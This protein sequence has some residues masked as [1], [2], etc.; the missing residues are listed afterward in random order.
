MKHK[1]EAVK[2]EDG[3]WTV[4]IQIRK[5]G[6]WYSAAETFSVPGVIGDAKRIAEVI[7]DALNE[8]VETY[9]D[10]PWQ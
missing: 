7:A 4:K 10:V 3:K 2:D 6:R 1:F 8:H 5:N 9:S